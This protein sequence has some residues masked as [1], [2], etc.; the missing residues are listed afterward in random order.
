MDILRITADA[1][2][3]P[4]AINLENED[5][6]QTAIGMFDLLNIITDVLIAEPRKVDDYFDNLPGSQKG[7]IEERDRQTKP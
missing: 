4:N 2:L 7:A 6:R 3:H 5:D 1:M